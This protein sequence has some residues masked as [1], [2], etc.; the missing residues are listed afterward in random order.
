ML[1]SEEEEEKA[2]LSFTAPEA[3]LGPPIANPFRIFVKPSLCMTLYFVCILI[4]GLTIFICSCPLEPCSRP[5]GV[6]TH[7][8]ILGGGPGVAPVP[9]AQVSNNSSSE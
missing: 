4:I 1:L 7:T 3:L 9:T 6:Q 8:E 2:H 5:V